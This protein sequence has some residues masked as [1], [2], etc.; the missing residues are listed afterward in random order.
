MHPFENCSPEIEMSL[1]CFTGRYFGSQS[2]LSER[3]LVLKKSTQKM[4]L[5]NLH[6]IRRATW[7]FNIGYLGTHKVPSENNIWEATSFLVS[8]FD[9]H[10]INILRMLQW[11]LKDASQMLQRCFKDGSRFCLTILLFKDNVS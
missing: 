10:F 6:E 8:I 9:C 3:K 7:E 5:W 4:L 2:L 1:S 11:C